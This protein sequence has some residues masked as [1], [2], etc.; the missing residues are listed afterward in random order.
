M[1]PAEKNDAMVLSHLGEAYTLAAELE[2]LHELS[3]WTTEIIEDARDKAAR[4]SGLIHVI[5]QHNYDQ[6]TGDEAVVPNLEEK[7]NDTYVGV[8]YH[9][10]A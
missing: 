9:T 6:Y 1:S 2:K 4:L 10:A 5:H 7:L 3:K 8:L